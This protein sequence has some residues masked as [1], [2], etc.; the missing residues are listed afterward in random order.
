MG[1][2]QVWN[3]AS[4]GQVLEECTRAMRQQGE[5]MEET[6]RLYGR[7]AAEIDGLAAAQ[8]HIAQ[9]AMMS[10][11]FT[12][13]AGHPQQRMVPDMAAR[14]AASE[15]ASAYRRQSAA[16]QH[17]AE[18]LRGATRDL[19]SAAM[20]A[21][22]H[23]MKSQ[24]ELQEADLFYAQQLRR[25]C[26]R[27]LRHT[28]GLRSLRDG[29]DDTF[30]PGRSLASLAVLWGPLA[31]AM[32]SIWDSAWMAG[33]VRTCAYGGDPVNLATGNFIYSKTDIEIRGRFPLAF[34]RAYNSSGGQ[35]GSLGPGWTHSFD[36]RLHEA[37]GSA[38]IAYGDGRWESFEEAGDG[39]YAAPAGR[40]ALLARAEGGGHTLTLLDSMGRYV[41]DGGGRLT[42]L[43][44]RN[45]NRTACTYDGAGRLSS[46][47][48]PGGAL[49]FSYGE[50]GLLAAVSDGTGRRATFAYEGGLLA[51]ATHP[52]GAVHGYGY[53]GKGRLSRLTDPLGTVLLEN[54]YDASGRVARQR[55][56]D[57][58]EVYYDYRDDG[59][60]GGATLLTRQDGGRVRYE[61]DDKYRTT[62]IVWPD[63]AE[64]KEFGA[65]D[66][67][68]SE[69]DK[70]G[71]VTR[72]E[73]D[74]LGHRTRTVDALGFETLYAYEGGNLAGITREGRRL[75]SFSYDKAGNLTAA[76]D[77]L[78]AESALVYGRMGLP[79]RQTD[80]V[81][82]ATSLEY[83]ERGN[84]VAVADAL[85]AV[86]RYE[87]DALN[88][89]VR[90]VRP[91]GGS[92]TFVYDDAGNITEAVNAEGNVRRYAYDARGKVTEVVDWDGSRVQYAYN[93]LGK[94]AQ[95]TDPAGGVTRYEYDKMWNVSKVTNAEGA[96]VLYE[97]DKVGRL[98]SITDPCG[99]QTTFG[100]DPD[101]NR[102]RVKG[103]D[104]AEARMEHDALNR[105]TKTV[106]ADGAEARFAYD[107]FNNVIEITDPA[108]GVYRNEYDAAGRLVRKEDPLGNSTS[109]A[110]DA[111]G[112]V[113]AATNAEGATVRYE[114]DLLGRLTAFTNADGAVERYEYD[115][116]GRMAAFVDALG[117]RQVYAYDAMDRVISVTDPAGGVKRFC[118]DALDRVT[119]KVD[120]NGN[121]TAYTYNAVGCLASVTG[122]DG[123]VARYSYDRMRRMTRRE[124]LLAVDPA[125]VPGGADAGAV[126]TYAY[127]KRGLLVSETDPLGGTVR[128]EYDAAGRP[129]RVTAKDG[130]DTLY[131]RELSG[132]LTKVAYA[133]GSE[134]L[135]SYGPL[136][137][138]TEVRD[139]LGLTKVET[140]AIGRATEVT[141]QEGRT[142]R[143]AY[144]PT[145]ARE[146]ITYPDGAEV[147][148]RYD[149]AG[150]IAEVMDGAGKAA[151]YRYD[152]VGHV[153]ER[154]LAS[155]VR[156][157][158]AYGA[159][160]RM[161]GFIHEGAD[162]VLDAYRYTYDAVGNKT[163]VTRARRGAGGVVETSVHGYAYDAMNRLAGVS[164]DGAPVRSYAYDA[165]GNR[166]VMEDVKTGATTRYEYD[167]MNRLVR[168]RGAG[169]ETVYGY[170][171]RGNMASITKDGV[172]EK[173]FTFDAANRLVAARTADGST[174][175]YTYDGIGR[176]AKSV[177]DVAA[178]GGRAARHEEQSYILDALKP[179]EN[180]LA[181]E[182]TGGYTRHIWGNELL[183]AAAPDHTSYYLL[184]EL[185]S[186]IR[187]VDAAGRSQAAYAY[188]EFGV[189]LPSAAG[190]LEPEA[191]GGLA[192][193]AAGNLKPEAAGSLASGAIGSL[194][195]EVPNPFGFTGYQPDPV[196]GLCYA[197]ARYYMPETARFI[198]E[199]TYRGLSIAPETQNYYAYCNNNPLI[200][201]DPT[202]HVTLLEGIIAHIQ[203]QAYFN[204]LHGR[205]YS[206]YSLPEVIIDGVKKMTGHRV[207]IMYPNDDKHI[208]ELYEIKPITYYTN[209]YKNELAKRQLD[210]YKDHYNLR[211]ELEGSPQY[212]GEFGTT[213]N[214]NGLEMPFWGD[215]TKTLVI[216][217]YYDT[218]PGLIYYDIQEKYTGE[219]DYSLA[220]Q[221]IINLQHLSFHEDLLPSGDEEGVLAPADEVES[222]MSWWE[223][224]EAAFLCGVW[225]AAGVF[226]VL[227]DA[228]YFGIL[229]NYFLVVI[230]EKMGM[231]W[232]MIWGK[233]PCF[234]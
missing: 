132:Q 215:P 163:E 42:E 100:Y 202:G 111:R 180:L 3:E 56:A 206:E 65:G 212:P 92:M 113:T 79:V 140:D 230:A 232:D 116:D 196:T 33:K 133:D 169:G 178:A 208:M 159:A 88:R 32:K 93:E 44:D 41:F 96:E 66:T 209:S 39:R 119:K 151:A 175:A 166:T 35:D 55:F 129:V 177:W 53:D 8:E 2:E 219:P 91:E 131:E 190:G 76:V 221:W 40:R 198:S 15:K 1:K 124:Q 58:G 134:V 17:A 203:I 31:A 68:T 188:D 10:A 64:R 5:N 18:R 220:P 9:T 49:S 147:R 37:D 216:K 164:L 102:V 69:T 104:G 86:T 213:F 193:E 78:G 19:E 11:T 12:D 135:L 114:Y 150:R 110:H 160:G 210:R 103:P 112:L 123:S 218:D 71:N 7:K 51:S 152:A 38:H 47:S 174:A 176:R 197:Q 223:R 4:A 234:N 156:S 227:D 189:P 62:A 183:G 199:D 141:D 82:A 85:G 149:A 54:T 83:D 139:A 154:M 59:Y 217:T 207:D 187:T 109:F 121:E 158:Y 162:G 115:M 145:G 94:L 229:D 13:G 30:Q 80:A 173:A 101:G 137:Q 23:F 138:L 117:G 28:E 146:S 50:G 25:L 75:A 89:V 228:S 6:A 105:L 63:G 125:L 157:S 122:A 204:D 201:I 98:I 81:G 61:R 205:K 170:D 194:E 192:L 73:Y 167:A 108:G 21:R 186:P 24:G 127:D 20:A 172:L 155:G 107:A 57:G 29:I 161:E 182:G 34:S 222:G 67:V 128:Y 195:P 148:Y 36:I 130:T 233:V 181:T 60:G 225:T 45:G 142:V 90:T 153:V 179:F 171:P 84:V 87:Y 48:G 106:D 72:H 224:L 120:E 22:K 118:Y 74:A 214:P 168:T 165:L 126:T 26:E 77:A 97:Y 211:N 46:V 231:Y 184:D 70:R 144:T 226:V 52:S 185:R 136:R 99:H 191:A 27:I 43:V 200:Y 95:V 16:L 14:A 143:Y